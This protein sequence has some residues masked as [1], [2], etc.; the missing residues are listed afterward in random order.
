MLPPQP[1]QRSQQTCYP[2]TATNAHLQPGRRLRGLGPARSTTAAANFHPGIFTQHRPASFAKP[3]GPSATHHQSKWR[4]NREWKR[5]RQRQRNQPP[6]LPR[7]PTTPPLIPQHAPLPRPIS[8]SL[9]LLHQPRRHG[10]HTP[11]NRNHNHNPPSLKRGLTTHHHPR[12]R[13]SRSRRR[14]RRWRPRRSL[15]LRSFPPPP[16]QEYLEE[17]DAARTLLALRDARDEEG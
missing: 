10:R 4:R 11:T 1:G 5:Q 7:E 3:A 17:Q 6:P 16:N 14:N 8:S 9:L 13:R 12:R 15:R 2:T